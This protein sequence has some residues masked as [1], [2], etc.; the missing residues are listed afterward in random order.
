[1]ATKFVVEGLTSFR[2]AIELGLSNTMSSSTSQAVVTRGGSVN[3]AEKVGTPSWKTILAL[4]VA[5]VA[6]GAG[7]WYVLNASGTPKKPKRPSTGGK[8]RTKT[9][10]E[11]QV[12]EGNEAKR[13]SEKTLPAESKTSVLPESEPTSYPENLF[14]ADVESLSQGARAELAKSAKT[15]GNKYYGEK[16]YKEAID[17][18]TQAIILQ[19]DAVFYSNR[20]AC[21]ANLNDY[22]KVVEDCTEALKLDP[23][24]IK[25]LN[26]RAQAYENE[27][28][29]V[30]ALNDYTVMCVLEEFKNDAVLSSTDRVLK[31]LAQNKAK[32]AI[33]SKSP[34]LP[35]D[36]FIAAYMDSFR[37]TSKGTGAVVSQAVIEEGDAH[38]QRAFQAIGDRKWDVAYEASTASVESGKLSSFF[39]PLAYNLRATFAFLRGDVE[40]ALAD[41]EKSLELD[42]K[43]VNTIIKRASLF[44]ERAE[45][46]Q[47]IKE[48]NRAI[49]IDPKDPDVYYHSTG[50]IRVL[51]QDNY[52]A[53]EDYKKS[54]SLDDTFVYA[55]IQLGVAQYKLGDISTAVTTFEKAARKFKSS[56]EVFNYHGEILL[57]TQ[58]FDEALANFDKAIEMMPNSPLPYINKAILYLQWKQDASTAEAECRKAIG[59][60]PL[61]DMAYA[62]LAQ[63]LLHQGKF[64]ESLD[65]YDKAADLARTEPELANAIALREAAAA[66]LYVARN[67]PAVMARLRGG[68]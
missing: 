23:N 25:A 60:D 27:D 24:Y 15:L 42:P 17:L 58:R 48:Y 35:S 55:H 56:G 7:A 19:P 65:A 6:I 30:D 9:K 49:E 50:Q 14:P 61:C 36:T 45:V 2:T 26:R 40:S 11:A 46:E 62:Q 43:N 21:Y 3:S 66:Q 16:K 20:A 39:E 29:W 32:E 8:K 53:I 33:K 1:M 41:L 31:T 67:Y 10:K 57:D 18:Y 12:E 37:L 38:L 44:M 54:I 5:G 64:E 59:V 51:T 47:A 13:S 68:M 34:R 22:D 28:R 4:A 63:L 52:G